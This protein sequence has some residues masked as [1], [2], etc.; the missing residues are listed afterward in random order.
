MPESLFN[1]AAKETLAQVFSC[2]LCEISKNTFFMQHLC[3]LLLN[4]EHSVKKSQDVLHKDKMCCTDEIAAAKE[5][6]EVLTKTTGP[7]ISEENSRLNTKMSLLH[8]WMTAHFEI[9]LPMFPLKT[10]HFL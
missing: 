4:V 3:W 1:K 9:I 2:E 8:F 7:N 5:F 6:L 10:H